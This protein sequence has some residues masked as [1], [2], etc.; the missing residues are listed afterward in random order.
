MSLELLASTTT[1]MADM[2]KLRDA[3]IA[4]L[5]TDHVVN[6]E[7]SEKFNRS[8]HGLSLEWSPVYDPIRG[9]AY[10]GASSESVLRE[11]ATEPLNVF[12]DEDDDFGKRAREEYDDDDDSDDAPAPLAPPPTPVKRARSTATKEDVKRWAGDNKVLKSMAAKLGKEY[13]AHVCCANQVALPLDDADYRKAV[14]I[15]NEHHG[16]FF[17]SDSIGKKK[18]CILVCVVGNGEDTTVATELAARFNDA[19]TYSLPLDCYF[20]MM[21]RGCIGF[22]PEQMSI[23]EWAAH[24]GIEIASITGSSQ[25]RFGITDVRQALVFTGENYLGIPLAWSEARILLQ[26]G[27]PSDCLSELIHSGSTS[28]CYAAIPFAPLTLVSIPLI[29]AQW[30]SLRASPKAT[31]FLRALRVALE[32]IDGDATEHFVL[33]QRLMPLHKK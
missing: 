33:R 8:F 26:D 12:D 31:D 11:L 17:V 6:D 4:R 9:R 18:T 15:I 29:H 16:Q 5:A 20:E 24:F 14:R 27:F 3:I 30:R 2:N 21:V 25:T 10:L 28:Y 1:A 22:I 23:G 13:T 32:I 7:V 19:L